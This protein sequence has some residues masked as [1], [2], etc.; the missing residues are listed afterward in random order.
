MVVP[1]APQPHP[2]PADSVSDRAA[3]DDSRGSEELSP[4]QAR[5]AAYRFVARYYDYERI[6]PI[7]RVLE[8]I[9][10]M[11]DQPVCG[12]VAWQASVRETLD[13]ASLPELPRPWNS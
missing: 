1:A 5:E 9:S 4:E 7:L 10:P 6:E 11:G 8:A 13:G 3:V 2:R 12:K